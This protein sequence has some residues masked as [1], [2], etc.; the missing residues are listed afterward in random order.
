MAQAHPPFISIKGGEREGFYTSF[1][2]PV[3][4]PPHLHKRRSDLFCTSNQVVG[5][6]ILQVEQEGIFCLGYKVHDNKFLGVQVHKQQGCSRCVSTEKAFLSSSIV[7]VRDKGTQRDREAKVFQV[8]ND[9]T[10]VAQRQLEDKQPEEKTNMDC[11]VKEQ[12][13]EYQTGWKIKMCNVL[14]YCN[15]RSA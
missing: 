7:W 10:A 4:S 3:Y 15:Q 13:K 14:D 5:Y 12:E 8:S 9:D 11:L 1:F 2:Q 6:Q